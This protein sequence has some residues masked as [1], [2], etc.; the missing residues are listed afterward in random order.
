MLQYYPTFCISHSQGS[1]FVAPGDLRGS[2]GGLLPT[3]WPRLRQLALSKNIHIYIYILYTYCQFNG[4]NGDNP[5]EHFGADSIS[6]CHPMCTPSHKPFPNWIILP[7][8]WVH[9]GTAY[10]W[11]LHVTSWFSN[12]WW[13][14]WF[15]ALCLLCLPQRVSHA[16][17]RL[18]PTELTGPDQSFWRGQL[19]DLAAPA[20]LSIQ[21]PVF[22]RWVWLKIG[23]P[24]RIQRFIWC[25]I[26]LY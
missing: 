14:G 9:H 4:E 12:G 23:D 3:L 11:W 17:N 5:L 8:T 20:P 24:P 1:S 18:P 10:F 21:K 22:L 19:P 15:M 7:D 13:L 2:W 16:C 6:I 25:Y 26:M